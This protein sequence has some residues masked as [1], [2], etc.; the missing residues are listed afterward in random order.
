M[1]VFDHDAA[2]AELDQGGGGQDAAAILQGHDDPGHAV[3]LDQGFQIGRSSDQRRKAGQIV[4]L[5]GRAGLILNEP[6]S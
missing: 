3:L 2:H 4:G 6:T 5:S 1:R